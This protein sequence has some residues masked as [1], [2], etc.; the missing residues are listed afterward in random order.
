MKE[1][2][3]VARQIAKELIEEHGID[4]ILNIHI[5]RKAALTGVTVHEV[6][7]QIDYFRFRK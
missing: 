4:G 5:M 7:S 2:T 1:T 6:L 3:K